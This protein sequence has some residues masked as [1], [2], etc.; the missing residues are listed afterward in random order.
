MKNKKIIIVAAP[1]AC[2]K[3]YVSERLAR[4]L[5]NAAYIDKDDLSGFVDLIFNLTGNEANRD[6]EFF[7]NNVRSE[8]YRVL[9][10]LAL[11]TARFSDTVIINAPYLSEVRNPDYMRA[12]KEKVNKI[13]ASLV[14]LWV[15]LQSSDIIYQR[16]KK[17]SAE[18][19]AWKLENFKTYISGINLTPPC[20]LLDASAVDKLI[21]FDNSSSEDFKNSLDLT[22]MTLGEV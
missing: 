6:G 11:S 13:G 8:E 20:E 21:I 17:R 12:L 4:A 1:P 2:G 10:R 9:E 19:D 18:R 22:L 7:I 3:N 14:L 5:G 16:M 15:T